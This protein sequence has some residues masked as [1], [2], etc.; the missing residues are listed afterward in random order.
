[1]RCRM[2]HARVPADLPELRVGVAAWSKK[3]HP[4][5]RQEFYI[6]RSER[7]GHSE[8]IRPIQRVAQ[9]EGTYPLSNPDRKVVPYAPQ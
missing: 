7:S 4:V 3:H 1:M 9:E 6:F 8:T 2:R 5:R